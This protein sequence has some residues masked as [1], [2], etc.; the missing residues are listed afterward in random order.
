[1]TTTEYAFVT[2]E[3][4]GQEPA[5]AEPDADNLRAVAALLDGAALRLRAAAALLLEIDRRQRGE[6]GATLDYFR[7]RAARADHRDEAER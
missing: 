5:K 4:K 3:A 1:M 7:Q 6:P 2:P